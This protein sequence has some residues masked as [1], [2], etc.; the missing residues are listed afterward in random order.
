[1]QDEI[2]DEDFDLAAV[3]A[4]FEQEANGASPVGASVDNDWEEVELG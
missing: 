2:E 4:E 3:L 1:V